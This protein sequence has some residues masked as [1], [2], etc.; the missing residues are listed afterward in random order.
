VRGIHR[1]AYFVEPAPGQSQA[2]ALVSELGGDVFFRGANGVSQFR[3]SNRSP[4]AVASPQPF[5]FGREDVENLVDQ[6]LLFLRGPGG[7]AQQ[8]RDSRW[9]FFQLDQPERG[10]HVRE[11]GVHFLRNAVEQDLLFLHFGIQALI[12]DHG[13]ARFL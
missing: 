9:I 13:L 7:E 4:V 2:H 10:D 8:L 6:S 11:R 12:R 1:D 3:F 5:Q